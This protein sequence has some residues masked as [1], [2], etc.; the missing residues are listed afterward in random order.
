MCPLHQGV[1]DKGLQHADQGCLV[2]P[3]HLHNY[4]V[5]IDQTVISDNKCPSP[6]PHLS[7]CISCMWEPWE[8]VQTSAQLLWTTTTT[9]GQP[10]TGAAAGVVLHFEDSQQLQF[11]DLE[12]DRYWPLKEGAFGC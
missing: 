3:Q 8:L 4:G 5:G 6:K 11:H 9:D 7:C 2:R 10:R 1:M 12:Y